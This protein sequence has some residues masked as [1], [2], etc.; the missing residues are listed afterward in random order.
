MLNI[1]TTE[2]TYARQTPIVLLR[3]LS[4]TLYVTRLNLNTINMKIVFF[5]G[6]SQS[7]SPQR[8]QTNKVASPAA[9]GNIFPKSLLFYVQVLPPEKYFYE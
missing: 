8:K 7:N 3:G 5:R 4:C 9:L 6:V 1:V 2:K